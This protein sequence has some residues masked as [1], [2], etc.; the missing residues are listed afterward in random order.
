VRCPKRLLEICHLTKR[1]RGVTAVDNVSFTIGPGEI[2][3]YVGPNGAG[4]STTVKMIVGLLEPSDCRILYEG[5][6]VVDNL[7][8]FQ[9]RLGYVPEEPNLYPH[10]SG[11]EYLQLVGR[12]RGLARKVLE[13]KIEEF[14]GIFSMWTAT[15]RSRRTPRAGARYPRP[16]ARIDARAV[17]R[18]HLRAVQARRKSPGGGGPHRGGHAR[19]RALAETHGIKFELVRHFLA[20]MLDGEWSSAPGQWRN[21]AVGAFAMLLPAGM[22]ILREVSINGVESSKYRRLA[23]LANPKP[24]HAA[25]VADRLAL[26]TLV[27]AV[28]GLLALVQW[29]SFFP[30]RRDYI[31]LAGLPVGSR[32][33]FAAR[34][35]TVLLFSMALVTT[36]NIVP[37]LIAP[38]EFGG[39]GQRNASY[40]AHAGAQG[41]AS[42]LC[43]DPTATHKTLA[44]SNTIASLIEQEALVFAYMAALRGVFGLLALSSVGVCGVTAFVVSGRT[45]EI[46]IRMALGARHGTVLAML[47]LQGTRT[48]LAGLAVGLIPAYGLARVMCAAVFG[49][50]AAGPA[51]FAGIPLV[52]AAAVAI[53][54]PAGR[55]LRSTR[56]RRFA[57]SR[58]LIPHRCRPRCTGKGGNQGGSE[59]QRCYTRATG[60]LLRGVLY[61]LQSRARPAWDEL[62]E[63]GFQC[64]F[65]CTR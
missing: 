59:A 14:L 36:I 49:V 33:I 60:T 47:F 24:F 15:A 38:L 56:L 43:V 13:P 48:A 3:G 42:G 21:V 16:A 35:G 1:F 45:H 51:V 53:W 10:L 52:L 58:D 6:S 46:G 44:R 20:R 39:L 34:F 17:A 23:M 54:I 32:Q 65:E 30:G 19:V 11:L 27:P 8:A 37:A 12:L 25:A 40:W 2:L 61:A 50:S 57:T 63:S 22:L 9:R 31:A 5:R 62:V 29:Q 28:T 4:K 55:A 18:R 41:A 26:L 64:L 7:P